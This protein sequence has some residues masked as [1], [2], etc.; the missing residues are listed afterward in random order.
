MTPTA[1]ENAEMR[2]TM[3][4]LYEEMG[5]RV[6]KELIDEVVKTVGGQS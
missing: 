1:A 3:A 5:K 6:G 4:P 2:K